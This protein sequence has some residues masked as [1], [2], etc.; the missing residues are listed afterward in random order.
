[1][2][3]SLFREPLLHFLLAGTALFLLYGLVNGGEPERPTAVVISAPRV[4]A[5]AQNFAAVWMR[6]PTAAELKG[7][8]DDY[9]A[10]EL[11][12]REAVAMGLDQDDT[13]V[14]R[15]LRQKMEFISESVADA[16]EPSDAQ[17]QEFLAGNALKFATS[18]RVSLQQVFLSPDRRGDALRAD[19]AKVL[20]ALQSAQAP[21]DPAAAG[22]PTL[23]P[24]AVAL[25]SVPDLEAAFGPSFTQRVP[26]LP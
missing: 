8:V 4:E 17:L 18:D 16:V 13:V 20:L 5:I 3:R 25:A 21:A 2:M 1:M 24:P 12:Y 10:E 22:D 6:P 26:A 15:R 19:A 11:Y 14:R 9:L 23:L 7:L